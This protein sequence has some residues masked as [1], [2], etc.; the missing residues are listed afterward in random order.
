MKQIATKAIVLSR[1]DFGETGRILTLLTERHGKLGVL[2]KGVRKPKSK[3]AGGVELFSVSDVVYFE[4][5]SDIKTLVSAQLDTHFSHIA[6]DITRSMMAYDVLKFA[7]LYTETVCE[8]EYF[9]LVRDVLA[10]LNQAD[11]P[12]ALAWAWFG[13]RL[14]EISGRAINTETDTHGKPLKADDSFVF[15]Y[16]NMSFQTL[17]QGPYNASHVKVLRL[18][19]SANISQLGTI[20]GVGSAA[21]DIRK[22]ITECINYNK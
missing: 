12:P 13:C 5:K 15:D 9:F 18:C 8:D 19:L 7:N 6:T 14:L 17:Q 22:L 10:A 1:I 11:V 2:A 21:E 3:L 16:E 20:G 4:G